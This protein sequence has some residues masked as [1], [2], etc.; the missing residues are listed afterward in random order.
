MTPEYKLYE[1][2]KQTDK[3]VENKQMHK[4]YNKMERESKC[5]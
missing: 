1:D 5:F 4:N 2:I 3:N